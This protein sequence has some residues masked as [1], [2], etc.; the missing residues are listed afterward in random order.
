MRRLAFFVLLS[1]APLVVVG[2]TVDTSRA[3]RVAKAAGL[4]ELLSSIQA[5]SIAGAQAQAE[6]LLG[7]L[8]QAGI[9]ESVV[10]KVAPR[11]QE[12]LR[13]VSRAWDP[14][15][16]A[17]IYAEGLGEALTD[18]EL[19]QAERYYGSAEG[20]KTYA[21]IAASQQKMQA[22]VA[23][24]TNEVLRSEMAGFVEA[25]KKAVAESQQR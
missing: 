1:L 20:K 18:D 16:A 19:D 6:S 3:E 24:R 7:Q 17:R 13:N 2:Q 25:V 23:G 22:Y 12:I 15:V 10:A 14:K 21:A 11:V 9:S 4:E 5:A 8:R